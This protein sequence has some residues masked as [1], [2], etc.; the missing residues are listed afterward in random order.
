MAGVTRREQ[1]RADITPSQWTLTECS[2]EIRLPVR[3]PA[4]VSPEVG[5]QD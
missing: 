1:A 3:G 2:R 4:D 5:D